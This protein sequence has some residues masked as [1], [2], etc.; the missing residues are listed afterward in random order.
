MIVWMASYP[1]SGNHYVQVLI[2]HFYRCLP[3][4]V[5]L[6]EE[7]VKRD[8]YLIE[9]W[10]KLIGGYLPKSVDMIAMSKGSDLY[11]VKTHELPQDDFPAIY[12]VRDGRDT[13]ISYARFILTLEDPDADFISTLRN[14][15][16]N[17]RYFGGWERHVLAWTRR[18][19]PTTLIKFEDLIRTSQPENMLKQAVAKIGCQLPEALTSAP[20]TFKELHQTLP[21]IFRKGRIG[22]WQTEMPPELHDLFWQR[23]GDAMRVMGYI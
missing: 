13:L 8:K 3:Y 21:E 2:N 14:L 5:Y 20:P 22:G 7:L 9:R 12:L 1:R 11:F 10:K 16:I 6:D 23:H 18:Q 4:D 15:I 17:P 19:A